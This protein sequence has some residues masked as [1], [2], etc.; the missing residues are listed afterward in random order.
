MKARLFDQ[1]GENPDDFIDLKIKEQNGMI[2]IKADGYGDKVS[3]DKYGIPVII[4]L[5][6]GKLRVVAWADIN[7]EDCTDII[8][9]SGAKLENRITH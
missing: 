6:E 9:L 7:Q 1:S 8:D 5:Y 3:D 4:E 2:L